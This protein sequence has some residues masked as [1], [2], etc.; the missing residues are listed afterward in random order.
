MTTSGPAA[1]SSLT[2]SVFAAASVTTKS[3]SCTAA[4]EQNEFRPILPEITR[5]PPPGG[6]QHGSLG[7]LFQG[8]SSSGRAS[9]SCH[10]A[11]D[12]Q[13]NGQGAEPP[14]GPSIDRSRGQS[15]IVPG[16]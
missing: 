7:C 13:V 8:W 6:E 14:S 9:A 1:A 2:I 16:R 15:L 10:D 5:D 4:N 12:R 3:T 11:D